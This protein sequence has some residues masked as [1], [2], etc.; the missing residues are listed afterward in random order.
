MFK[1]TLKSYL[2]MLYNIYL[3]IFDISMYK[4]C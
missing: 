2:Y 3:N 4:H 1:Y